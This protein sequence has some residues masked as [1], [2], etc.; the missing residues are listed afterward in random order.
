MCCDWEGNRRSGVALVMRHKLKWF[1]HLRAQV[2]CIALKC[3]RV[4]QYKSSAAAEMG[5]RLHTIE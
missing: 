3:V 1:T 2:G 4:W 5:D